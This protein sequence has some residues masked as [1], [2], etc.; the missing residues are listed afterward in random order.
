MLDIAADTSNSQYEDILIGF[1]S[2]LIQ[3]YKNKAPIQGFTITL[4][5][6]FSRQYWLLYFL[7]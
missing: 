5:A 3:R 4:I 1:T 6:K 7:P 2:K